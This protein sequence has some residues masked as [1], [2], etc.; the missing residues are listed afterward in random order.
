MVQLC[1]TQTGLVQPVS[2]ELNKGKGSCLFEGKS[3]VGADG[4][5]VCGQ[6]A[7][8]VVCVRLETH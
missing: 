5:Q 2:L 3:C 6:V 4:R 8:Q 1:L 7:R